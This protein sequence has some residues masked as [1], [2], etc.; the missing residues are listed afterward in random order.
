MLIHFIRHTTP[1]VPRGVCYG[2]SDMDVADSFEQE[3]EKVRKQLIQKRVLEKRLL[4]YSSPLLR[5]VKLAEALFSSNM[6][7]LDDRIKEMHFGNWE[8]VSWNDINR[9]ELDQWGGDFV[10]VACP[11]GESYRAMYHRVVEFLQF[12]TE[13]SSRVNADID[14]IIVV[15]HAG[16]IRSVL[17]YWGK[18]T[19]ENSFDCRV[20]YGEVVTLTTDELRRA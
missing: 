6:I 3:L 2:Q 9:V 20:E 19:L 10:E 15:T 18:T 14:S 11:G 12:V 16:V 7:C 4:L 17:S 1:D 5:C 13:Y 8:M